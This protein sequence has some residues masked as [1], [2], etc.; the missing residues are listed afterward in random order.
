MM[1][2]QQE[3]L[4][5]PAESM[6]YSTKTTTQHIQWYHSF[7]SLSDIAGLN[8]PR[9]TETGGRDASVPRIS[10][11]RC[12]GTLS[13]PPHI[14][15]QPP[16]IPFTPTLPYELWAE[17]T[18]NV[19]SKADLCQLRCVNSTFNTLATPAVFRDMKVRNN[20]QSAETF[21]SLLHASHIVQHVQSIVYVESTLVR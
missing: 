11:P 3:Q 14:E 21:W 9:N 20:D 17:I 18:R 16:V 19:V 4:F 6:L 5:P 2:H 12:H 1:N 7:A 15:D 8:G 10:T 13:T